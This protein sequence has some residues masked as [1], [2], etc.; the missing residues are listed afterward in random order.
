MLVKLYRGEGL[1]PVI[2][3]YHTAQRKRIGMQDINVI[4]QERERELIFFSNG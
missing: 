2:L 3:Y 1:Y 4:A